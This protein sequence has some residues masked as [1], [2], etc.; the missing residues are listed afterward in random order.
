MLSAKHDQ[1][2]R[3]LYVGD[4]PVERTVHGSALLYRLL[5]GYPPSKLRV[6]E[7]LRVSQP[8]YRLPGVEYRTYR[9]RWARLLDT[10]LNGPVSTLAMFTAAHYANAIPKLL[11]EFR[12][13][14]VITV[15]HD[16]AWMAAARYARLAALPLHLTIHDDYLSDYSRSRLKSRFVGIRLRHVY[17]QAISRL[18][19][20]P[21]MAEEY[22]RRS[23]IS[24]DVLYPARALDGVVYEDPS[25][26]LREPRSELTI[27][28]GGSLYPQYV[29]VLERLAIAL[30]ASGGR[31]QIFAPIHPGRALMARL[32]RPNIEIQGLVSATEFIRRCRTDAHA[33]FV[34]MSFRKT[35]RKNMEMAFPSKL[36]DCTAIGVPLL[37]NGPDYCSAVMWAR[38]NPGVAEVVADDSI[39]SLSTAIGRLSDP[40]H[41]WRLAQEAIRRG[42]E[43][44]SYE[45]ATSTLFDILTRPK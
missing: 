8:L 36:A 3:L 12:P 11:D 5:S 45:R 43:Y 4:V 17:Q 33:V 2:P 14:A 44:F 40:D 6:V 21:F 16:C 13:D 1:L 15:V 32:N 31:L 26:T 19:V 22:Q 42:R 24:G 34:P 25:P 28:F 18:C 41:R 9:P 27:V 7:G 10:R 38:D 30:V 20:S 37:I 39:E 29:D 23:G 35:D